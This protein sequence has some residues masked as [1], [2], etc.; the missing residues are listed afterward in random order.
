MKV[1]VFS[2]RSFEKPFLEEA[3]Q[4]HGHELHFLDTRLAEKTASI[5]A[6]YPAVSC[7]VT[8]ALS[9]TVIAELAQGTTRLILLRSAGFN[10]VDLDA[11][12]AFGLTV[13]RV[14]TYSPYAIAEFA[15]GLILTLNRKIHRAYARIQR[16]NFML[17][18]L[19]GFDL[20][21]HTVGIIGT[22]NIGSA[23]AKIMHG[24][25]CQLLAVDPIPN[26][27]C[28]QMGVCYVTNTELYR[29]ADIIS[30]H[31]PLTVN[32][33]HIINSQALS[34]MKQGVMLINTG[35]GALIDTYAVISALKNYQ[36]GYLG[37]DVYEEEEALF[38][39]DLSDTI[40][41]DDIFVRLQAFPNV[42]ITAHQGFLTHEALSNIAKTTL[43]NL[44]AFEQNK[45]VPHIN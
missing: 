26:P 8:D 6:A 11:A 38:S 13:T 24:F 22:G 20:R 17:D 15:V 3:N 21:N 23:F 37:L 12:R 30:L 28:K 42:I 29:Q 7:A 41:Q 1:A 34:K 10:H 33:Y 14:P 2:T 35:R 31:C 45:P 9:K 18:G 5:A 36:I 27:V 19:L 16:Q 44:T 4:I 40:I 39:K 32:S 25:G 43:E